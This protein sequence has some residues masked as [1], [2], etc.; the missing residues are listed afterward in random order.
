MRYIIIGG[1]AAAISAVEAIRSLDRESPIDLFSEED[2]PLFSR[3][4]LPYYIAEELSKPLLNFRTADFFDE[5]RVTAHMG[6]KVTGI[7]PKAK[8]IDT[9][10]N[11]SYTYDRLLIAT[12]GNAIVPSIPGVEMAG[13][14]TLKTMADAERI[15]RTKG[16]RAVVIGAG[17]IGV[18]AC[19][20]L[21]RRGIKTTLLEQLGQ[22]MPTVFDTEAAAIVQQRI[23]DLGVEVFTGEKALRFTGDGSVQGV[24]TD[25]RE[26]PCDMVVLSVGI[27][28]A[29]ELA[30]QAGLTIG[31]M[32]GI[33]VDEQMMTSATDIYAAGD[34]AETHDIA[35]SAYF[36]NAIWPCAFEQGH[37]AGLNMAGRKTPYPGSYRRN[38]IGNFIG[39]PAISMGV[40]QAE[41]CVIQSDQDEFREVRVRTKDAYKKLVLRNG[42]I[43]GAILVGQTQKA[44][45]MSILL[46]KQV[47]IA[48]SIPL[49]MS[50]RLSFM[51]LLPILRRNADQFSEPEYKELIDTGL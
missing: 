45:L 1:S 51:D 49:L 29:A 6:V 16:N 34:V 28:P 7:D 46:R 36:L 37:F 3:V 40:T 4:L 19:I 41:S 24:V 30:V 5:N 26:I 47:D 20:S 23:E 17:S 38:S 9:V 14:S 25:N 2:T 43:I 8:T 27:R 32:K 11:Q 33:R 15:Y 22:V 31:D 10:D 48:D 44:G 35:R 12:G 39:I 18:E 50:E 13:I 21:T 42:K